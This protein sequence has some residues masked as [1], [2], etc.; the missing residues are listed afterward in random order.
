MRPLDISACP[1]DGAANEITRGH[2]EKDHHR[3]G[4]DRCF[5]RSGPGAGCQA[6]HARRAVNAGRREDRHDQAVGATTATQA[7]GSQAAGQVKTDAGKV[8]DAPKIDS[9]PMGVGAKSADSTAT[10]A[11]PGVPAAKPGV[12]ATPAVPATGADVK[13]Q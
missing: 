3:C 6:D 5:R 11:S 9:K 4:P 2:N 8:A 1:A 10:P 7:V 13:K 12:V